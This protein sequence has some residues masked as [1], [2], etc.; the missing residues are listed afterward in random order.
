MANG[1]GARG[2][3]RRFTVVPRGEFSLETAANFGFGPRRAEGAADGSSMRMAFCVDGYKG[4]AVVVLRQD[5]RGVHGEVTGSAETEVVRN[6]VSRVLS[7]DQD[8]DAWLEVGERD[9]VM[10]G[11]QHSH[12][13]VRPVLFYSPYEAASWSIISARRSRAQALEVHTR[14]S[15]EYGAAFELEGEHIYAWPTPQRTLELEASPDMPEERLRRLQGVGRAALDGKLDAAALRMADP[16]QAMSEMRKLR[17]IG[18]FYAELIVVRATGVTDVLPVQEPKV[19]GYA[20]RFYG[21]AAPPSPEGFA[22]LA[23][24]WRP[25]RTWGAVL[26]RVAGDSVATQA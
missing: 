17:G 1:E 23:E 5:T 11:L 8:G 19:R 3:S 24:H 20:A 2:D 15:A 4:H 13:G 10:D 25:F 18:P 22:A 9:P 6:Q 12:P 21:L 26:L 7:L 16:N 14:L